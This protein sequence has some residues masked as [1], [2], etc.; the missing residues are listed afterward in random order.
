MDRREFFRVSAAAA[1]IVPLAG[2]VACGRGPAGSSSR[3]NILFICTDQFNGS[4]AHYAGHPLVYTPN[5]DRLARRG[6]VFTNCYSNSPVCVPARAAL[7]TG[8]YPHEVEAYDNAAPF[9]GR[10]PTWA[11]RLTASGYLCRATGKLDFRAGRDYG[12][13]EFETEHGHGPS[14][15]ITAY[16]RNPIVPRIDSR[17]QI[18][19][20]IDERP[21][22]D[23]KYVAEALRF[24][25][26]DL[27]GLGR[28]PWMQYAGLVSPHPPWRV[29]ER[30]YRMYPPDNILLPELPGGWPPQLHPELAGLNHYNM[31]DLAP[32]P[33]GNI[34]RARAAYYG[35][36]TML[37]EWVGQIMQALENSGALKN[38][39][40]VF[41]SDHGEMLGE[42]GMWF[43]SC[44]Y[45]NA[46]RVPLIIAGP[47]FPSGRVD[48]PVSHVDLAATLLEIAGLPPFEGL[49][50]RSL[51]PL[52][53][54][55]ESGAERWAYGELNNEGNLTGV[56][57]V[58][59]GE[60]KY[61]HFEGMEPLLFN[62]Q[63]DPGEFGNLAG[64]EKYREV[65]KSL[66]ELLFDTVNPEKIS[67]AAFADQRRRL[68]LD[69]PRL[70]DP[71]VYRGYE[72][73][74]GKEFAEKLKAGKV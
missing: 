72:R 37:D 50:G 35:S 19:A 68:E 30:F 66:K 32:F 36:I 18:E 58:R 69:L 64:R 63:E 49:R 15:D 47:G 46:A 44:F 17:E 62:L 1:G 2:P 3:P 26:R 65:E 38:T 29:P 5:L 12:M 43:K 59:K 6:T 51:Q 27:P 73:R 8:F 10:F 53:A 70:D 23:E 28:K 13:Q 14:P 41:T 54:G 52:A 40:V 42:H 25:D 22:P 11:N 31:F 39:L 7:F 57:W 61:I 71:L 48:S 16:F 24:L 55:A 34:L 20:F 45:D 4:C 60:W 56:F 74:L 33:E 9:D 67:V 21:S